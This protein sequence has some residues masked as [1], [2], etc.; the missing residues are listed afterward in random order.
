MMVPPPLSYTSSTTRTG[1][2]AVTHQKAV[3][4]ITPVVRTAPRH[5]D[6]PERGETS[7]QTLRILLHVLNKI[8]CFSLNL[9]RLIY[10]SLCQ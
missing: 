7:A 8:T 2:C 9:I 10:V 1:M 5:V 6:T 4:F 3:F